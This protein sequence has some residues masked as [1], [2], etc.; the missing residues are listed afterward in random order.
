MILKGK[1]WR[2]SIQMESS[3]NKSGAEIMT[4]HDLGEMGVEFGTQSLSSHP[5]RNF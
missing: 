4:S 3:A 1:Q 5:E 2:D